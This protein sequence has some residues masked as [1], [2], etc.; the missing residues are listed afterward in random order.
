MCS[1][2]KANKVAEIVKKAANDWHG[3]N[4]HF[5]RRFESLFEEG[6]GEQVVIE[7]MKLYYEDN[8][9]QKAAEITNHYLNIESWKKVYLVWRNKNPTLF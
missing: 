2:K 3:D 1:I 5:D 7:F 8:K 6:D 9:L 4:R